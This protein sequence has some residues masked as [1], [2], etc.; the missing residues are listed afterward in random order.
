MLNEDKSNEKDFTTA[1]F[2]A[3]IG[4]LVFADYWNIGDNHVAR[5]SNDAACKIIVFVKV[6]LLL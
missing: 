3:I 1:M 4:S 6:T 2:T 5:L